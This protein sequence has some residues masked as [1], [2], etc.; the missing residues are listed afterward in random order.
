MTVP[1]D[2][3]SVLIP[4]G[5]HQK[6]V[7]LPLQRHY[8][9]ANIVQAAHGLGPVDVAVEADFVADFDGVR[10][11]PGVGGV[12]Q[13]AL[14]EERLDAAVFEQRDLLGVA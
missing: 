9:S 2:G 6:D 12:W 7:C 3:W 8:I 11:V 14:V 4:D 10:V 5:L 1:P 13:D